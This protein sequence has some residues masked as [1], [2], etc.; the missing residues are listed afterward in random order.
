MNC[1]EFFSCC[2]TIELVFDPVNAT[3]NG[4]S[5]SCTT[6]TY[7]GIQEELISIIVTEPARPVCSPGCRNG[8]TCEIVG[9]QMVPSCNCTNGYSGISCQCPP[10]H[11]ENGT[12]CIGKSNYYIYMH[13]YVCMYCV[14]FYL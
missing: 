14:H 13:M 10:G 4:T 1:T 9:T 8:G 5:Y 6:L 2:Y 3:L 12:Q 11:V 7:Y